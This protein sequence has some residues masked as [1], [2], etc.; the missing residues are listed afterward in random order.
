MKKIINIVGARPNFMK[1]APII[2]AFQASGEIESLLVHTGQH[3]DEKMSDLFFHQLGIP[4]PDINLEAGSSSH[5]VQTANIMQAFE[6]VALEHRPDAVLVVGDVNSTIACGLVAVKL[7]IKL[8]HVEAGLRSF[9]RTM[10]E[11]INRILTDCISDLLFCTEQSGVDNL[12]KEGIPKGKIFLVGNVMIDTL[13][14]NKAKAD[15][16]DILERLGLNGDDFATLTL[17]RPSNVDEPSVFGGIL[18]AL[19]VIQN[20]MPIIFPIHPRTLRNLKSFNLEK[21]FGQLPNLKLIEPLGYLDFLKIMSCAKIVLTD[22]GGIQEETTIL[23]VPCLTLRE[24]TERPVTAESGC[25]KVVGTNPGRIIKA[26]REVME[27]GTKEFQAPPLWDGLAAERIT[28]IVI[29]QWKATRA[30]LSQV[31]SIPQELPIE[32]GRRHSGCGAFP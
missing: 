29:R 9:D 15:E 26:Y 12:I 1:I 3:Y 21:R 4:E 8:I 30:D 11:E 6:P 31:K 19:E 32:Q 27:S 14:S 16:S 20:D 22:S 23:K 18:D 5:A 2:R 13:L 7:G 25:N 28:D 10:P 24:N 17:H